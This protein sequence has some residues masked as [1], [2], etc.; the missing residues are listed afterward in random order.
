VVFEAAEV[1]DVF[2][3]D[4]NLVVRSI[5]MRD[6]MKMADVFGN[7]PYEIVLDIKEFYMILL[8]DLREMLELIHAYL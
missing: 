1:L 6:I 7:G 4:C 2:L 8:V 5:E 3:E